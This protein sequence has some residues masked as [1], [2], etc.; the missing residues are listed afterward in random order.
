LHDSLACRENTFGIGITLGIAHIEDNILYDL[1]GSVQS[2]GGRVADIQF[3]NMVAFFF[4]TF[5]FI[6]YGTSDIIQYI[7][8]L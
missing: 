1:I 7:V 6:H 5:G 8:Q 3:E 4:Q 2:K